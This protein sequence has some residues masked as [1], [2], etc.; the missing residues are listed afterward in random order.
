MTVGRILSFATGVDED[1]PLGFS[2]QPTLTFAERPS[3]L[4][5]SNT[6]INKMT[7]TVPKELCDLPK[8]EHICA[9]FDYAFSNSYFGL[10]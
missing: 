1:P 10:A 5:T 3:Y 8:D 7:L 9:M 4:P 2:V 6:C